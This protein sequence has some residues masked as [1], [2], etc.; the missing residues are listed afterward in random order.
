MPTYSQVP[1][2]QPNVPSSRNY[3]GGFRIELC[4]KVLKMGS[5][6]AKQAN[7]RTV[8]DKPTLQAFEGIHTG[9]NRLDTVGW[10]SLRCD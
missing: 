8:L 3:E 9:G 6:L 7:A 1:G 5:E 10:E 2:V 4:K